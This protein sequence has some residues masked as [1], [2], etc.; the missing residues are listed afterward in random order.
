MAP[1]KTF[2]P[3]TRLSKL[4][5]RSGGISREIAV[6][7]SMK[8]I[9]SLRG[10]GDETISRLM[11]EIETLVGTARASKLQTDQMQNVLQLAD[12]IVTLTGTF[13]YEPLGRVMRSL[14]DVTDGLLRA[15]LQD[16]API[17]VH[18]QSMRLLS[19]GASALTNQQTDVVLSELSKILTH[20]KFGSLA[21]QD[22]SGSAGDPL[23]A[24]TS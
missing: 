18:I 4:A 5:A 24:A 13:G 12:Q 19:P 16:A 7:N 17:A 15:G 6:E 22:K 21:D 8:H 9:E 1:V 23:A 2:F 11:L 20:Y 3:E 10:E 14:C